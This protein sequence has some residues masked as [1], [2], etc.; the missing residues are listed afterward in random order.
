MQEG[1]DNQ[2]EEGQDHEVEE[3]QGCELQELREQGICVECC[4][5]YVHNVQLGQHLQGGGFV[6]NC[7]NFYRE[8][9]LCTVGTNFSA[10]EVCVQLG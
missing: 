7:E 9:G 10:R 1:P 5:H 2:L 6:Y 4:N 3:E 8:R